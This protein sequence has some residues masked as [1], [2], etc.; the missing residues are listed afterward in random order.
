MA[1]LNEQIVEA[2]VAPPTANKV[3]YFGGATIQGAKTP[4][5]FGVRVTANGAKSFVLNYRANRIERRLTIGAWPTWSVVQAVK[6]AR[7][8]RRQ[9]DAGEDPLGERRQVDAASRDT[10][11]NV[12]A[13]FFKREGSKLRSAAQRERALNRLV[14]PEFGKRDIASIKRSE[15]IRLLDRIADENGP[16]MANRTRAYLSR[17]CTWFAARSDDFRSPFVK[18]MGFSTADETPRQR[19]LSDDEIRA[20]WKAATGPFGTLCRFILLTAAR[21]SEAAGLLR[22]EVKDGVWLLPGDAGVNRNKVGVPLARLARPLTKQALEALPE[23]TGSYVFSLTGGRSPIHGLD[24][25]LKELQQVSGVAGWTLHDLRRTARSLMSRAGVPADHAERSLGHTVG[26][27]RATYDVW[28]YL[29]EKAAAF[30][31]LAS[32]VERI[33]D[34]PADN[35]TALRKAVRHG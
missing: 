31:A 11:E 16:V 35:V 9:I 19:V 14:M 5:G 30:R 23:G 1:R 20:V 33:V 21:R 24:E 26:R 2:M 15:I 13:E 3:V 4:A 6:R 10:L 22:D 29:P 25:R 8:L 28:G 27:I 12:A 7:E 17:V 34:P 18:G 32:L